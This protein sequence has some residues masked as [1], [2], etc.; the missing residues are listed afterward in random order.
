MANSLALMP[1]P[2][3]VLAADLLMILQGPPVTAQ[4]RFLFFWRKPWR[5]SALIPKKRAPTTGSLNS[6]PAKSSITAETASY[7]PRR[8]YRVFSWATLIPV[9]KAPSA[10]IA[11][12]M[13]LVRLFFRSSSEFIIDPPSTGLDIVASSLCAPSNTISES[14]STRWKCSTRCWESELDCAPIGGWHLPCSGPVM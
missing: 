12:T 3:W 9:V 11:A 2:P 7:P 5:E 1:S 14:A 8:S 10:K 13:T 4:T 6:F